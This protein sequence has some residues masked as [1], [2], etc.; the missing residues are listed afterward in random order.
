MKNKT[1][2][3]PIGDSW[4]DYRNGHFTPEQI[5]QAD[6]KVKLI[7][8]ILNARHARGLSQRQLEDISGVSQPAIARIETGISDPQLSTIIKMLLPLGK[9]LA[10]IPK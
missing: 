8:E 4:D 3:S 1:T 10:I 5:A 7:G 9:T 2:I 6:I